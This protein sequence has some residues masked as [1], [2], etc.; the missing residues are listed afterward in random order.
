MGLL[1]N[2]EAHNE[3]ARLCSGDSFVWVS[4]TEF[5]LT[6]LPSKCAQCIRRFS[7]VN[8]GKSNFLSKSINFKIDPTSALN[9][10][11]SNYQAIIEQVE[12][13][14]KI[15]F[16]DWRFYGLLMGWLSIRAV[17]RAALSPQR[18]RMI[19]TAIL[20]V[21][22]NCETESQKLT[23]R[24]ADRWSLK[25]KWNEEGMPIKQTTGQASGQAT[26]QALAMLF[27][28]S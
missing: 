25:L 11:E 21:M 26:G 4:G 5:E 14:N 17:A 18:G 16:I 23:W 19:S 3:G 28:Y 22:V 1:L 12:R 9:R 27:G 6:E 13:I 7:V 10:P 15:L 20:C 24:T 2:E 8:F